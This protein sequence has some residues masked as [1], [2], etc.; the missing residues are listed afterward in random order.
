M[1]N[2]KEGK[3]RPRYFF[4]YNNISRVVQRIKLRAG[5]RSPTKNVTR[6]SFLIM[7]N[8]IIKLH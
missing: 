2:G 4:I 7:L 6:Y 3:T 1:S 5:G 8:N